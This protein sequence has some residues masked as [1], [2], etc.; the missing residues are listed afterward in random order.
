ML[1]AVR[2]MILSAL[3]SDEAL[4][5]DDDHKHEGRRGQPPA[6]LAESLLQRGG[7][8]F[9]SLDHP[10]YLSEFGVH[11]R[12]HHEGLGSSVGGG[13]AHEQHVEPVGQRDVGLREWLGRLLH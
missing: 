13:C 9:H 11:A 6:E 8:P 10:G 7:L 5:E 3:T 12:G 2:N 1:T 4:R